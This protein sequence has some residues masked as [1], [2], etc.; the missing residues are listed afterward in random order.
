[1][2]A[3]NILRVTGLLVP[4]VLLSSPT[5][6]ARFCTLIGYS[7][8]LASEAIFFLGTTL[9][10]TVLA[11]PGSV[12]FRL[13]VGHFGPAQDRAIYGQFVQV[14]RFGGPGNTL[15][16]EADSIVVVVPWDYDA[17]CRPTPWARSVQFAGVRKRGF[18]R[19]RL[20]AVDDWVDGIPT[21]DAFAPQFEAFPNALDG[22]LRRTMR[23]GRGILSADELFDL[24]TLVPSYEQLA[25]SHWAA[26]EPLMAW[27]RANPDRVEA[28]PADRIVRD[29]AGGADQARARLLG[30]PIAGTY[31]LQVTLP[32]GSSHSFFMRTALRPSGSWR[33]SS[34]G[35]QS[36]VQPAWMPRATGYQL[37]FWHARAREALPTDS[38]NATRELRGEWPLSIA[39]NPDVFGD[40]LE[41]KAHLEVPQLTKS[42]TDSPELDA[43][44]EAWSRSFYD[45]WGAGEIELD[46]ARFVQ[47]ESGDVTFELSVAVSPEATIEIFGRRLST[48]TIATR[49]W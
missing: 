8:R 9:P 27:A 24:H 31:Q 2:N 35:R 19:P 38:A 44:V 29:L 49:I 41:W 20:R 47:T 39:E 1:M 18:F 30:V 11:G 33:P 12:D 37:L 36:P 14:E 16:A 7:G 25:E 46:A 5:N 45:R 23:R 40:R 43:L 34:P 4:L 6:G 32:S 15:R 26:A 17:T 48:E 10:D 42:I 28:Y 22:D 3:K 13:A 21:F